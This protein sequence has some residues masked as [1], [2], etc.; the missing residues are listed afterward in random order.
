MVILKK[1]RCLHSSFEMT[2]HSYGTMQWSVDPLLY[3]V[4]SSSSWNTVEPL[5]CAYSCDPFKVSWLKACPYFSGCLIYMYIKR[6]LW[7]FRKVVKNISFSRYITR[8]QM[9]EAQSQNQSTKRSTKPNCLWKT[10]KQ[11]RSNHSQSSMV[12]IIHCI[13]TGKDKVHSQKKFKHMHVQ[14]YLP[15]LLR[16]SMGTEC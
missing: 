4:C 7:L 1:A 9:N 2:F 13:H 16:S 11:P 12:N 5:E 15:L 6:G 8:I 10:S 14:S 3:F